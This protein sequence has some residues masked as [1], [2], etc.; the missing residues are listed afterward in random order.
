MQVADASQEASQTAATGEF[1]VAVAQAEA[2]H[3]V[4]AE[5][6]EALSGAAQ[7]DC[8]DRAD[9]DLEAAKRRPSCVATARVDCDSMR[10][11]QGTIS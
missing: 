8:K 6:C 1:K 5:K 11:V 9:N 10:Q 7:Q 4:A 2:N 3:K